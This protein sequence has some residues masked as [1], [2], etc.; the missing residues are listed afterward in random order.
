MLVGSNMKDIK[1]EFINNIDYNK[2]S[3]GCKPCVLECEKINNRINKRNLL[4]IEPKEIPQV[5]KVF[6]F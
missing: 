6:N 1:K 2:S 3:K 4:E 5:L